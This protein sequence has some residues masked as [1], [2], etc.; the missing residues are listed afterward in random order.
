M[1]AAKAGTLGVSVSSIPPT[2]L[3][4]SGGLP[5]PCVELQNFTERLGREGDDSE[6]LMFCNIST[7]LCS[8]PGLVGLSQEYLI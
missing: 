1:D 5:F 6:T 7:A 4:A 3:E 8:M 2:Q